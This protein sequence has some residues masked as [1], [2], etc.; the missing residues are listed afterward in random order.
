VGKK[1]Q[2]FLRLYL[3]V[4]RPGKRETKTGQSA[5]FVRIV[6]YDDVALFT[7]PYL[8]PGSEVVV[9]GNL[10][11]RRRKLGGGKTKT[12]VEVLADDVTFI[13]KI[14][15]KTG[16]AE[17]ARILSERAAGQAPDQ[18]QEQA[19]H[20]GGFFRVIAYGGL[21]RTSFPYLQAGSEVFV[22]GRLQARKRQ[23]P[24]GKRETVV[25]VVAA[26]IRFLRKINW[27]LGDA[28]RDRDRAGEAE[29]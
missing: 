9:N 16:D 12:V 10:R 3:A 17:R 2:P 18:P 11:S 28:E 6:A 24:D 29:E 13:R 19:A 27:A 15:W 7:Y 1:D 25:E 21:A 22:R 14:D 20:G 8:Q 23:L 4:D 26:N 5:D